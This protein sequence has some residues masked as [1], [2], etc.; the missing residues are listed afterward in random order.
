M[1]VYLHRIFARWFSES[2]WLQDQF[3]LAVEKRLD[4]D[5]S[6]DEMRTWRLAGEMCLVR[7]QDSW[8]RFCRELIVSSAYAQPITIDGR[9]V[10]RAEN[11][12]TRQDV[13]NAIH[14]LFHKKRTREPEWHIAREAIDAAQKIGLTN[15]DYISAALGATP[16]PMEDIR[17]LRNYVAHRSARSRSLVMAVAQRHNV[18]DV[19]DAL[20][21][22]AFAPQSGPLLFRRWMTQL[23]RMAWAALR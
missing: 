4:S 8:A 21:V 14:V 5:Y 3:E 22:A 23:Q 6:I 15:R 16:S 17:P 10:R 20:E 13:E 9:T 7:A 19:Q 11:I 18:G 1:V 2:S 12:S